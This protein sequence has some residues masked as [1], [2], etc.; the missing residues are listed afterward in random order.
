MSFSPVPTAPPDSVTF[1]C[2]LK[3]AFYLLHE[4]LRVYDDEPDYTFGVM[5]HLVDDVL[6]E[7]DRRDPVGSHF[8]EA[9]HEMANIGMPAEEARQ[10][11]IAAGDLIITSITSL[12]EN[13]GSGIYK[14]AYEYFL[15]SPYDV[16][17]SV[18][19]SVFSAATLPQT[20]PRPYRL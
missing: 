4:Q 1:I 16:Y 20:R 19:R 15:R 10:L 18:Q 8:D 17:I 2:S 5:A 6:A 11:A 14:N 12:I 13:F 7:E 3:E 9:L